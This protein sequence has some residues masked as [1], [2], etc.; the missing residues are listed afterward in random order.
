VTVSR[1]DWQKF[2]DEQGKWAEVQF[3]GQTC[4]EKLRHLQKEIGEIL[5]DPCDVYEYA[6][7]ASLLFDAARKQGI[8]TEKI[9]R[10]AW[11]KLETNKTRQW[12]KN[13]DGTFS[14]SHKEE[15]KK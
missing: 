7:A 5:E 1:G 4:E 3:D 2:Q 8:S 14:G 6:D 11:D 10:A 13:A 12:R 15:N 9:L